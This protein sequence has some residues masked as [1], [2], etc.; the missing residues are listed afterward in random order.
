MLSRLTLDRVI[1]S[2]PW[3][4]SSVL[5][6]R[7]PPLYAYFHV[8]S[9]HPLV[10]LIPEDFPDERK[11]WAPFFAALGHVDVTF[12]CLVRGPLEA[13]GEQGFNHTAAAF[14]AHRARYPRQDLVLL[15]NNKRQMDAF[16]A[17]QMKAIFFNQNALVDERLLVVSPD[18]SRR[19]DAIYNARINPVKR[20]E[21]ATK[22]ENLALIT[23]VDG[24]TNMRLF[25]ELVAILPNANWLNFEADQ[26][27]LG[28]YRRIRQAQLSDYLN[29]SRCG[30]CLSRNE[31]AMFASI[32][33]LLCGLPVVSTRSYGGRDEFYDEAYV[34]IVEDD[35]EAVASGVR[36]LVARRIPA[37]YIREKTLRKLEA[38]RVRLVDYILDLAAAKG[39]EL[40]RQKIHSS[41]FPNQLYSLKKVCSI[42]KVC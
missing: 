21:L 6:R 40:S 33:Y 9:E 27:S 14:A 17:R 1:E 11:I 15:A 20:H 5:L 38:H 7:F 28:D 10:V 2:L 42:L 13:G 16:A 24:G 37:E 30:L 3:R 29:Q 18:I 31:G 39:I 23:I 26:Y 19:F 12:L 41:I 35:P 32:E 36:D 4:I 25:E 34:A 8:L 22:V